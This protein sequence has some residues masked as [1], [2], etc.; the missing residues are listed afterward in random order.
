M[1]KQLR[2]RVL[3]YLLGLLVLALGLTL[4][5][6]VG[7]GVSPIISVSFSVSTIWGFNFGNTTLVLYALFVIAQ[8]ALH[9]FQY[10]RSCVGPEGERLA[11]SR[12]IDLRTALLLDALQFPL[13]LIF[14][15]VLNLFSS[16]IPDLQRAYAGAF[17]GSLAGRLL[18]LCLAI[19]LTGVG[20]AASL[21]MRLVPN[22]GDGIVQAIA[23]TV[24]KGV[25]FTKNCFDVCNISVTLAISFAFAGR[26][27]GVGVGTVVAVVGVG[28]VIAAFNHVFGRR[29]TRLAG[30][31]I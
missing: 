10:R 6:K 21:N 5:T 25:G 18:F 3:F 1:N 16:W 22:P 20:A 28:R 11:P 19:V 4:N 9:L 30:L 23:D 12:R 26:L 13:S 2:F 24:G 8:I 17:P 31:T 15:R 14:T 27:T 29:M 7:L